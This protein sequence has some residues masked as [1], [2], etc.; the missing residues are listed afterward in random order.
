[1]PLNLAKLPPSPLLG[2]TPDGYMRSWVR[3]LPAVNLV[4]ENG[5][6]TY[7]SAYVLFRRFTELARLRVRIIQVNIGVRA[8]SEASVEA[9]NLYLEMNGTAGI[10]RMTKRVQ[11]W[12]CSSY[13][14]TRY[15]IDAFFSRIAGE[16]A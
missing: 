9:L 10:W 1:M 7:S 14:P 6:E 4:T 2:N 5:L 8:L 16:F 13:T 11:E 12:D 3:L 15:G